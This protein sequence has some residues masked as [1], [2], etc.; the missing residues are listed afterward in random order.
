M[1]P[2]PRHGCPFRAPTPGSS[3]VWSWPRLVRLVGSLCVVGALLVPHLARAQSPPDPPAAASTSFG[4]ELESAKSLYFAGD[5]ERSLLAFQA[6]QLRVAQAPDTMTWEE[7]V[8][9]LSYLGEIHVK[10]GDDESAK[11]AFRSVLEKDIDT[12]ISPYHHPAEVV[13]V[14]NRVREQIESERAAERPEPVVIP[15]APAS[16]YLPLGIPQLARG[17]VGPGLVFGGGQL[18]LGGVAVGM[19]AHLR[20]VNTEAERHPLGWTPEQVENRVQTLRYG[21]QWPTTIGFY[22][23]WAGSVLDA[24]GHWRRSHQGPGLSLVPGAGG[25]PGLTLV[26]AWPSPSTGVGSH[27][28]TR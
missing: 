11:R 9:A 16:S 22:L 13:F 27:G 19:Y 1:A 28:R 7:A 26:G 5:L 10:M 21:V 8:D 25:A 12:R 17:R 18:A 2:L 14:F 23:L 15:R 3:Q 20:F 6:L 4:A 24:R